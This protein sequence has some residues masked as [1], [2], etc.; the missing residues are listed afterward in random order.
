M[1]DTFIS[2][3]IPCYNQA[4][5]L[6]DALESVLAQTHTHWECIIINDGSTDNTEEVAND[7]LARDSRIRYI[8]KENGGLSSAR[9]AGLDAAKGAFIQFLDADDAIHPEKFTLQ[10]AALKNTKEKAL[11]ISSYMSSVA[12]D[13]T[14]PHPARFKNPEFRTTDYLHDLIRDW[15]MRLSIPVH[16]FLFKSVFFIEENIR[17]NE[18]LPNHED[19]ECWM[20]IFRLD[21][22]V[23]FVDNKLAIYRIRDDAMCYNRSLMKQGFLLAIEIQKQTF[24]KGSPEYRMLVQKARAVKIKYGLIALKDSLTF[25]FRN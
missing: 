8:R 18:N 13:L 5:Y 1:S 11:S 10:L 23:K 4:I 6:P 12:D 20:N 22:E 17:F 15:W 25:A 14:K 24:S 16:C 9:N 3:I 2:I 19:W 21:P 7:W